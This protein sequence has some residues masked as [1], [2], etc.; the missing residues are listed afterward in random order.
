M[1]NHGAASARA[2]TGTVS[3]RAKKSTD[4][5][6]SRP[7]LLTLSNWPVSRRLFAV[8]V[9]ALVMG[10]VFGGL[11][12]ASA[13]S[14]A[15]QFGRTSQ[16]ATLGQRLTVLIQDLQNER[17][18]TLSHIA[19]SDAKPL[20]PL[21]TQTNNAV[22]AVQQSAG[23]IGGAFPAN[24]QADVATVNADISSSRIGALHD[25]LSPQQPADELAVI[26]NYG[27]D[28]NEMITLAD[29]VGQ[30]VS[31]ATLSS[32]VRAFNALAL[33]KEQVSRQRALLN[34]AFSNGVVDPNTAAALPVAYDEEL[35]NEAAFQ[36]SA[37]P[38]EQAFFTNSL[39]ASGPVAMAENL[40]S[41][42]LS[43]ATPNSTLLQD[44]QALGTDVQQAQQAP[45]TAKLDPGVR[46]PLT[47]KQ[48]QT[49]WQ[50]GM[51]EKINALQSTETL[52][53]DNIASRASQLQSGAQ[54]SALITGIITGAVLL[55]VLLAALLVARS[56]VLPLRRLRAGALDVAT[57][58]LPERVKRLSESPDPTSSLEVAPIDVLT[59]DEIGQVARAFDQVHAEAVR[60][61]G[62]EALLRTSFNAMFVNLSRRTQSLVE[63]L[64]RMIDSLEQNEE[65]PDRLS[66]LFSMDHLVT[67]MRRNSENLLLLAGHEGARKWSEAVSLADVARAATSEIEQYNRVVLNIQPGVSV[68][69]QAVSD[70]VHLLAELLENATL[71]SPK[72]TQVQVSA[73]ELSSGGVLIEIADKGIGVSEARLAEMN[74]RLDNTPA[75]DVSVSRHM[76]LFAVARL[77]ERHRIRIRLRP[78]S[79]QGLIAL[80]WLPESVIE[81]TNQVY[82]ATGGWQPIAAQD[83]GGFQ[84]RRT[85][86]QFLG[87]GG[88]SQ[89]AVGEPSYGRHSLGTRTA[90]DD[91]PPAIGRSDAI[92][93]PGPNGNDGV[94]LAGTAPAASLA[95]TA[96][97]ASPPASTWF[98]SRRTPGGGTDAGP[99]TPGNGTG[100]G[101]NAPNA[102]ARPFVGSVGQPGG[103]A[104]V[105]SRSAGQ[106]GGSQDAGTGG[107]PTARN[108]GGIAA[109]PVSG[110]ETSA[111][112]PMRVPKAN[113]IP[114]SAGGARDGGGSGRPPGRPGSSHEGQTLPAPLPQRS[115]DMARSRLSGFQ[116]GARRAE[117]QTPRA[118]EGTDR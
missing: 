44:V 36:Q 54:Q 9:M 60:L 38:T 76:G 68:I 20:L 17:D 90:T 18:L 32:D 2:R 67:R 29:Q 49:A 5:N 57:V 70:V 107:W 62:D 50:A 109:D 58:Q 66:N 43:P 78:A 74:W 6:S 110:G 33:A 21:Y 13:E 30:G 117:G 85:P 35:T 1:G 3:N 11:R 106:P 95:G 28:I 19:D 61:A 26:A 31:D 53:A 113:L 23:G 73:Q 108:P 89:Q 40:E 46:P 51:G 71:F 39:G 77:A 101:S 47:V 103:S 72:D 97:A 81:R 92:I 105:P 4:V 41:N 25:T 93:V 82:G 34:Y 59:E 56:L 12:V 8:I 69:G 87:N 111:G 45:Q 112:L 14:S 116:R 104:G 80:V 37:T 79:P 22:V 98:R 114:G 88:N 42:I 24:I 65:D 7:G 75:M 94:P 64:A 102:G 10:L 100:N 96:P 99:R 91:S 15:A 86:G 84:V 115:P 55:L 48:G 52:I 27:A 63:R 118:G 83:G 16:L